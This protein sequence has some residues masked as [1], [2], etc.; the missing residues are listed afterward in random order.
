GSVR[1]VAPAARVQLTAVATDGRPLFR[2]RVPDPAAA[3]STVEPGGSVTFDAPPGQ[4]QLRMTV[5]GDKG[6]VLD[7]SVRELT[8]PDYTQVQVSLGTPRVYRARTAR[9]VQEI[10]A[11]P[12]AVPAVDRDFS[13][14]ERILVRVESYAPGGIT[15]TVTGR[16]LNRGGAAMADLTFKPGAD[17]VFETELALSAFAAG[18]YLIEFTAKT[19]AGTA[20]DTIA[21]KVGR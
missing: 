3:A 18:E 15:P 19:D 1:D 8:V 13:R 7:S 6:Q 11:N 12:A 16:L 17:G 5:E 21:F 4:L 2:G 14:A 20:Q 10:R 9:D